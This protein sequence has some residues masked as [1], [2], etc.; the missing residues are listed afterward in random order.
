M[1]IDKA[2]AFK[3][4]ATWVDLGVLKEEA[5]TLYKLLDV[6]EEGS[7]G[8]RPVARAGMGCYHLAIKVLLNYSLAAL[9]EDVSAVQTI[10]RQQAEQMKVY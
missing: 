6:A 5:V 2:A 4:V 3:A 10:Q 9:V 8:S 1:K 7:S